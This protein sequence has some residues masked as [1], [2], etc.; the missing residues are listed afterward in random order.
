MFYLTDW[1]DC[2]LSQY[3]KMVINTSTV[4]TGNGKNAQTANAEYRVML[5]IDEQNYTCNLTGGGEQVI[6]IKTDFKNAEGK[7][8]E[9]VVANPFQ[10]VA[11]IRI[12][13]RSGNGAITINSIYFH[14][15]LAWDA[16]GKITF[17]AQDF[18][19]GDNVTKNSNT[20]SFKYQYNDISLD[21][22]NDGLAI[23]DSGYNRY[24]VYQYLRYRHRQY[25][26]V[27]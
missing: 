23:T 3:D 21:F 22:D 13:G 25:T 15:P 18:N 11:S 24:R 4:R 2:D 16:E 19:V 12:G 17:Y 5:T 9:S 10:N 8:P 27:L 6:N 7:T 20:Y 14:K 26:S 1:N